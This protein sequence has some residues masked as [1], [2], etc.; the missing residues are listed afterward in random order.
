MQ[1]FLPPA[2]TYVRRITMSRLNFDCIAFDIAAS[3]QRVWDCSHSGRSRFSPPP[4]V[5]RWLSDIGSA[6]P[7][8]IRASCYRASVIAEC[9][10][11]PMGLCRR[12]YLSSVC[13]SLRLSVT[14]R[15]NDASQDHEI[16]TVRFMKDFS[17]TIRKT[18][19]KNQKGSPRSENWMRGVNFIG[20]F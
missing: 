15:Q 1:K 3:P 12:H 6:H 8:D 19:L 13:L 4:D 17:F 10:V 7:S 18:F 2:I 16:F 14:L 9:P 20:N 5:G 11:F